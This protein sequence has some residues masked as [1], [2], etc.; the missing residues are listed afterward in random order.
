MAFLHPQQS[1]TVEDFLPIKSFFKINLPFNKSVYFY[2][3]AVQEIVG[4]EPSTFTFID[5]QA[6]L[7]TIKTKDAIS[8]ETIEPLFPLIRW[9]SVLFIDPYGSSIVPPSI[10]V[11]NSES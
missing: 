4:T 11:V 7:L 9:T 8:W 10:C 3:K 2:P 5:A 1:L 6:N